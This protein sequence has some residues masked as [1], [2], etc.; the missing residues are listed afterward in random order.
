MRGVAV[1]HGDETS[2]RHNGNPY[3][4]WYAGNADLAF[5]HLD[6]H[7]STEAA[8]AVFG[9]RFPG[10]LVAD[11]Y[12][13]YNGVHP[14]HRQSCLAHIKTKAKEFEHDFPFLNANT[15]PSTLPHLPHHLHS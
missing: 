3:W 7:R 14:K 6:Q 2:W 12:A 4:A 15:S 11:A 10:T 13:S 9:E 8:Q 1:G 5:F